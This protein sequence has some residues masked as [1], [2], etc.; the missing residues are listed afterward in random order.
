MTKRLRNTATLAIATA[1]LAVAAPAVGSAASPIGSG[2][3]N[4]CPTQKASVA[5]ASTSATDGLCHRRPY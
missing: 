5:G 1:L 2:D 4:Y 3:N